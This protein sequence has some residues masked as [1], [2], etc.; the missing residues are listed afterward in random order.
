[1]QLIL[2]FPLIPKSMSGKVQNFIASNAFSALSFYFVP[3]KIIDST[4]LIKDLSFD[5]PNKYLRVLGWSSGSTL[6][7]NLVLFSALFTIAIFHSL[8]CL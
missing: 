5:Q 4:P 7:N 8:F 3:S 1:M 2:V 6:I